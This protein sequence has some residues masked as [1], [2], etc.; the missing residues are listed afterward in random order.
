MA[1]ECKRT[2]PPIVLPRACQRTH[3]ITEAA[4]GPTERQPWFLRSWALTYLL[5]RREACPVIHGNS[6][7]TL[8]FHCCGDLKSGKETVKRN[9]MEG[10]L[11]PD[12]IAFFIASEGWLLGLRSR[13]VADSVDL[14]THMKVPWGGWRDE[15]RKW[16][17]HWRTNNCP[18]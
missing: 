15:R 18:D 5:N 7:P 8:C 14:V 13:Q 16:G 17:V 3:P 9:G 12:S 10:S 1:Q 2:S 11:I 4:C 6:E